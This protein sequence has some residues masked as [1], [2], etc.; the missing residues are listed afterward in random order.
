[1][2]SFLHKGF[3]DLDEITRRQMEQKADIY[4]ESSFKP[5]TLNIKKALD[6]VK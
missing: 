2:T 3:G 4:I 5:L 6:V 1:M